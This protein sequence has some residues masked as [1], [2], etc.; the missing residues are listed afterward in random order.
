M[1]TTTLLSILLTIS[2][3][4]NILFWYKSA[5]ELTECHVTGGF[6]PPTTLN[7][8]RARGTANEYKI[9]LRLPDSVT[10]GIITRAALDEMMCIEGCNG[11]GYTFA[12]D[13]LGEISGD[14][15]GS[16]VI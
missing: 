5:P 7:E 4:L 13:S 10:A 3:L 2:V 8:E 6:E 16:F 9:S 14:K 11:I 1:K 15:S 12:K